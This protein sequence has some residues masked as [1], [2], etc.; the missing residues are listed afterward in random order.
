MLPS[1]SEHSTTTFPGHSTTGAVSSTTVTVKVQL[2][3]LPLSSVA[4]QVTVVVPMPRMLPEAGTATTATTLSQSSVAV[5]RSKVATAWQRSFAAKV[6]LE[7]QVITGSVVSST[8][9]VKLQ[10][11]ELPA[12]SVA[13][14]VTVVVPI[15][16]VEPEAWL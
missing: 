4:V 14:A 9:T 15:A 16:K 1:A 13:V 2:A 11:L 5:G 6:R 3:V 7:G 12:A 8:V 10:V